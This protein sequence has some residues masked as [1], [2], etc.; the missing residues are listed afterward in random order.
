MKIPQGAG[1]AMPKRYEI[2]RKREDM[3]PKTNQNEDES[4]S[5]QIQELRIEP[6]NRT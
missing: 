5:I 6:G 2:D 1:E 3:N 4:R